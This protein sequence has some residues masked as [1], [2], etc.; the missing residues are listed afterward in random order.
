[1]LLADGNDSNKKPGACT[2]SFP[3]KRDLVRCS[4]HLWIGC[5]VSAS[6]YECNY[7]ALFQKAK[8][9]SSWF[10]QKKSDTI[11]I[12]LYFQGLVVNE[13]ISLTT[14]FIFSLRA[15]PDLNFHKVTSDLHPS[16]CNQYLFCTLYR[17]NSYLYSHLQ[18]CSQTVK[19]PVFFC[20]EMSHIQPVMRDCVRAY[21]ASRGALLPGG[22]AANMW[23][24]WDFKILGLWD[25]PFFYE[26]R[27][28]FLK[29]TNQSKIYSFPCIL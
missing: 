18:L 8:A 20:E 2:G 10:C 13:I 22:K 24:L 11:T 12:S 3:A 4:F 29:R 23:L 17:I 9:S 28:H 15:Y 27:T 6:S 5:P 1:M 7:Y 16:N 14:S 21:M 25:V 26:E 19:S